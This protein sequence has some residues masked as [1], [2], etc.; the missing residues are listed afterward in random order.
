MSQAE[1]QR[2]LDSLSNHGIR[3]GL[4]RMRQMMRA[5]GNPESHFRAIHVTGT[6]GKGSVCAMLESVL[7]TARY[8][9]GLYTS[10]HLVDVRERIRVSGAMISQSEFYRSIHTVRARLKAIGLERA[11]T[12]FEITTAAA[13][14]YF[15]QRSVDIAVVEVGL[16]GRW[17]AT[18]VL[19][20]PEL[21]IVTNVALDHMEYLGNTV[22]KIAA[23]KAGIL[24]AGTPCLTGASGSA[25]QEVK[26]RA[27][28]MGTACILSRGG[29][30]DSF[31]KRAIRNLP[32]KGNYQRINLAMVLDAVAL[33]KKKG[34]NLSGPQVLRGLAKTDWSARFDV[35]RWNSRPLVIDGAHN[36]A[37]MDE[38]MESVR[39]LKLDRKP[40]LL[41]FNALK[42]K[43]FRPMIRSLKRGL[44]ITL[45]LS[46]RLPT[47]RTLDPKAVRSAFAGEGV[48]VQT[49]HSVPALIQHLPA[50]GKRY[51]WILAAGSLYLAG[52]ILNAF[53]GRLPKTSLSEAFS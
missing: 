23:E 22:Q 50:A 45:V 43:S 7:R 51:E 34:W 11:I 27:K 13:F 9:T 29:R 15:A 38:L 42:D 19:P 17:D 1:T 41:I 46:P 10:P 36:P 28:T 53:K 16:G 30:K 32:L 18:N 52:G 35:R 40:C 49:F 24:K 14:H 47:P 5:L 8:K 48:P 21:C 12:Y 4:E 26:T 20:P 33:L 37:A 6:N 2:Y 25:L 3:P 44:S 31:F 39:K